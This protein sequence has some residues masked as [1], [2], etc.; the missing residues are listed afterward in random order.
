VRRR[1]EG[2]GLLWSVDVHL[3]VR[4]REPGQSGA[5]MELEWGW[6][7]GAFGRVH[8]LGLGLLD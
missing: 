6:E 5:T 3:R 4:W 1:K 7:L 2:A 8:N